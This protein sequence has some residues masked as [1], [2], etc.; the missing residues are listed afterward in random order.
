M[1][2]SKTVK[3]KGHR[4]RVQDDEIDIKFY[5]WAGPIWIFQ[6]STSPMIGGASGRPHRRVGPVFHAR[7]PY[8]STSFIYIYI[9]LI[10]ILYI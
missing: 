9:Y 10:Y 1:L 7:H 4:S 5:I 6:S 2:H 3:L 8:N